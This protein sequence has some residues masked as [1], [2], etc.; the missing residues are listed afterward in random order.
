MFVRRFAAV[1]ACGLLA[2]AWAQETARQG[3]LVRIYEMERP[4]RAL[5]EL[6]PGQLPNV[7]RIV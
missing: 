7:A 5:P 2:G 3:A 4:V 1:L 6:V